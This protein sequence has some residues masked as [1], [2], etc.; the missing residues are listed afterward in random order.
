MWFHGFLMAKKAGFVR[1]R[2]DRG[3]VT[4]TW[5]GQQRDRLKNTAGELDANKN[6]GRVFY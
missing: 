2:E 5:E 6:L 3:S 1:L 4:L